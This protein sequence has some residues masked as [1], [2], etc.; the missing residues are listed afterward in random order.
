MFIP[1]TS[2]HIELA[3]AV[4]R[5]RFFSLVLFLFLSRAV[6]PVAVQLTRPSAEQLFSAHSIMLRQ[7]SACR[8][9]C[10]HTSHDSSHSN[11]HNSSPWPASATRYFSCC[12]FM[13]ANSS[14]LTMHRI[15][16]IRSA[17]LF[18]FALA[19][20]FLW[21]CLSTSFASAL[22]ARAA[23]LCSHSQ[24]LSLTLSSIASSA[25]QQSNS[26]P[27]CHFS[28]THHPYRTVTTNSLKNNS[29]L[30]GP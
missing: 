19:S 27:L 17:Q 9:H 18:H 6:Q 8:H 28:L 1:F 5:A 14:T 12:R 4:A 30:E 15:L 7:L 10:T 21:K 16:R 11:F 3:S 20:F 29:I 25:A 22:A 2:P 26:A 24:L 23:P 13:E